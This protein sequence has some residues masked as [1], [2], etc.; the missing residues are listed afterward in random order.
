MAEIAA[1]FTRTAIYNIRT[2]TIWRDIYYYPDTVTVTLLLRRA[3]NSIANTP[4][5]G[6]RSEGV[7]PE[8]SPPG[9][10]P[11]EMV[12]ATREIK[13]LRKVIGQYWTVFVSFG[14]REI[15]TVT[16]VGVPP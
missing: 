2:G 4:L 15:N 1:S 16:M 3:G 11:Q 6:F 13:L 10:N 5:V 8:I 12:A 9:I 14:R 7:A